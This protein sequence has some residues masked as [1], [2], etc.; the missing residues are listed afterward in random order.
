MVKLAGTF[1]SPHV[2]PQALLLDQKV[3]MM[4]MM[5]VMTEYSKQ[6]RK[7]SFSMKV[8][9]MNISTRGELISNLKS[10]KGGTLATLGLLSRCLS[11]SASESKQT[12]MNII[13]SPS[14]RLYE[15]DSE[16][17]MELIS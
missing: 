1:T 3:C 11:T 12:K 13:I 4:T 17:V 7:S 5:M 9:E 2:Y 8:G 16:N 15:L 6:I 10:Q 14:P